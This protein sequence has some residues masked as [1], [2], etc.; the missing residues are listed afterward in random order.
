MI[1]R[2]AAANL[3]TAMDV[4]VESTNS[5]SEALKIFLQNLPYATEN[6]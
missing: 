2:Q 3:L 6:A 5:G 4:S 1:Y